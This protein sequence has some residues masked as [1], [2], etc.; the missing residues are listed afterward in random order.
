MVECIASS[1]EETRALGALIGRLAYPGLVLLVEGDLGAG[2]T[3][4][5][6]GVGNGLGIKERVRSPSFV[7]VN[8][9]QGRAFMYHL[10][11]Y[12][13]E[14][15]ELLDMGLEEY[16]ESEGVILIEWAERARDWYP[17]DYLR[18][19]IK[20]VENVPSNRR[21]TFEPQGLPAQ[22]LVSKLEERIS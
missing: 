1:P 5:A 17:S 20:K 19:I 2:K 8:E 3:C 22:E 13:L 11:L 12:R 15:E 9:Y 6:Q 16:M 21:L 10:D 4:F 7:L 14:E 18:V